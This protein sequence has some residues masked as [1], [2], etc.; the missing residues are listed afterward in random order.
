MSDDLA[1]RVVLA[2]HEKGKIVAEEQRIAA[3]AEAAR[4]AE[5]AAATDHLLG[6]GPIGGMGG[7]AVETDASA[8]SAADSILGG[9]N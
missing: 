5:D 9:G 1:E 8:E 3:E 6:G 7:G 2:C 4:K